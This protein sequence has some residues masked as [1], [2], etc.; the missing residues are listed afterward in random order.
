MMTPSPASKN[1]DEE[2]GSKHEDREGDGE[3]KYKES[4]AESLICECNEED[5]RKRNQKRN[6]YV[7]GE[8]PGTP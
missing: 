1:K 6:S 4:D 3:R 2:R 7:E 5:E 8:A